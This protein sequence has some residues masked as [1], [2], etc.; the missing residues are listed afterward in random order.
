[1]T[2]YGV[3]DD[4]NNDSKSVCYSFLD[5]FSSNFEKACT[6]QAMVVFEITLS[7]TKIISPMPSNFRDF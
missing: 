6:F 1:M 3:A 2:K 4:L 7:S 5:I